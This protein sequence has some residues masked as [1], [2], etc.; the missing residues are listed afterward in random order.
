VILEQLRPKV[1]QL[2]R[3]LIERAVDVPVAEEFGAIGTEF[4]DAGQ[5]IATEIRV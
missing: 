3:Q 1:E 4:R 5:A 2:M